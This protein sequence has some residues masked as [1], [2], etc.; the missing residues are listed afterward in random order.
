MC[1]KQLIDPSRYNPA[2]LN[3]FARGPEY[4]QMFAH[5]LRGDF[6]HI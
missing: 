3:A 1:R 5:E 6:G 4:Q 2:L